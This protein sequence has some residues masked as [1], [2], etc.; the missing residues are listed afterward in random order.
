MCL[1]VQVRVYELGQLSLKFER[2]FDAEIVDFQVWPLAQ[3]SFPAVHG[4]LLAPGKSQQQPQ[5]CCLRCRNHCVRSFKLGL[6]MLLRQPPRNHISL[7][8]TGDG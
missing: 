8:Q 6:C 1:C 7:F 5:T 2:H 4:I 3:T